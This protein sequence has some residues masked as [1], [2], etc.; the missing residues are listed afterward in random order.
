LNQRNL[1]I[2]VATALIALTACSAADAGA[3]S[4]VDGFRYEP[5]TITVER[6]QTVTFVNDSSD[7]HTVTGL[8]ESLPSSASYFASGDFDSERAARDDV[9]RGFVEPGDDYSVTLEKP[10]TYRYV[11]IPHETSGMRGTIVVEG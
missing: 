7:I 8:Q 11:C 4:M 2:V 6:G 5:S 1:G 10:G 3:V 9:Q